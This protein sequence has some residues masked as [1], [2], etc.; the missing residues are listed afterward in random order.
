MT[1]YR[2]LLQAIQAIWADLPGLVGE[3]WL[4]F[5][6]RLVAHLEQLE[7]QPERA[8]TIQAQIWELFKRHPEAHEHL[9]AH[10]PAQ[11]K[12]EATMTAVKPEPA[13]QVEG[14]AE[15]Q[16]RWQGTLMIVKESLTG[17]IGLLIVGTTLLLVLVTL[18]VA[19]TRSQTDVGAL[20]EILLFMNGLIGVVLGYYF[21]RVPAEERARKAESAEV[22][23]RE[24]AEDSQER[25]AEVRGGLE[26]L[27][28]EIA[29]VRQR[30]AVR[31]EPVEEPL[32]R[33]EERLDQLLARTRR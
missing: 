2:T 25:L 14:P 7:A 3:D 5:E 26:G 8:P 30:P 19:L 22:E 4:A 9:A 28:A 1:E 33:L 15:R 6:S 29:Q 17:C 31:G 21:G 20:K 13:K 11:V 18:L 12:E 32:G 23:A 24:K 10:L 16:E 27:K